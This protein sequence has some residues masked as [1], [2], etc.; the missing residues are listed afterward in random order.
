MKKTVFASI[1]VMVVVAAV[2]VTVLTW[3]KAKTGT[4]NCG[5]DPTYAPFEYIDANNKPT[6]FDV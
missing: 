5:T 6:V 3:C 4:L 2:M 1:V